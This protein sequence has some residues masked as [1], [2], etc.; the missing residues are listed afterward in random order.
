MRY[1]N[2]RGTQIED[3]KIKRKGYTPSNRKDN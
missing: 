1:G 2:S 3:K